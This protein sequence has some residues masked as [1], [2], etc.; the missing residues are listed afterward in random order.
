MPRKLGGNRACG[1]AFAQ[2]AHAFSAEIKCRHCSANPDKQTPPFAITVWFSWLNSTCIVYFLVYVFAHTLHVFVYVP[3]IFTM[4]MHMSYDEV[5]N[6]QYNT[7]EI[8]IDC[9][10]RPKILYNWFI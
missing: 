3:I 7:L 2:A 9:W 8:W 10:N 4:Y 6:I 5:K 1:R